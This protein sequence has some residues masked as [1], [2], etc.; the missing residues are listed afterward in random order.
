MPKL[1]RHNIDLDIQ[2]QIALNEARAMPAGPEKTEALRRAGMLRNAADVRGFFLLSAA[3]RARRNLRAF[4]SFTW[5][6]VG[7]SM[8]PG[9]L[10]TCPCGVRFE[11]HGAAGRI[12]PSVMFWISSEL[13]P[14]LW[15]RD[16]PPLGHCNFQFGIAR[17]S[18][19]P[20]GVALA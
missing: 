6:T 13:E 17:H 15:S 19:K 1:V 9:T 20:D 4:D 10:M 12:P 11:S 5:D 7:H 3:G 14:F 2:A 8:A 16:K 18:F